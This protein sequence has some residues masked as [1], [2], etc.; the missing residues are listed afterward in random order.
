MVDLVLKEGRS[1]EGSFG[2][3]GLDDWEWYSHRDAD[4]C[5]ILKTKCVFFYLA[6]TNANLTGTPLILRSGL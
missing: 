3:Q 5:F 4:K 6:V 2:S 1:S